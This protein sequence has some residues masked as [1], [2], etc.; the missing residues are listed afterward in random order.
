M[1]H[2]LEGKKIKIVFDEE[3]GNILSLTNLVTDSE[4]SFVNSDVL[5]AIVYLLSIA[6][7][8]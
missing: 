1:S 8:S 3:N 2:I 7:H 5:I 6:D 4:I